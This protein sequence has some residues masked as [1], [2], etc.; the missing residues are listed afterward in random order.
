MRLATED[1]CEFDEDV[2]VELG[3]VVVVFKFV[4]DP[5]VVKTVAVMVTVVANGQLQMP[6][7]LNPARDDDAVGEYT[8]DGLD[9]AVLLAE[10]VEDPNAIAGAASAAETPFRNPRFAAIWLISH[11]MM[12]PKLLKVLQ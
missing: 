4:A 8:G 6:V 12:P 10:V 1:V 9:E 3:D 7:A 11:I 5:N 2:L